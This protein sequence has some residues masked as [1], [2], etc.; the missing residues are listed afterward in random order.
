MK[1]FKYL[2]LLSMIMV[3]GLS[4]VSC[5]DDD[6]DNSSGSKSAGVLDEKTGLRVTSAGGYNYVYSDDGK[7]QYILYSSMC[8]Y[9]FSYS[10]NKITHVDN[11]DYDEAENY[12][13]SYNGSG[14]ISSVSEND[15]WE[16]EDERET[17]S[18]N[19]SFSY[20][21]SGHLTKVSGTY[22]ETESGYDKEDGTY[23]T[24][25]AS[26][27]VTWT[28]TWRNNLL[29]KIVMLDE[30]REDDGPFRYEETFSFSYNNESMANY[31][32]K[33]L[34]YSAFVDEPFSGF[35]MRLCYVGL[36]GNGPA[37]LPSKMEYDAK[38]EYYSD[39][40]KQNN[41]YS[42]SQTYSYDFNSEGAISYVYMGRLKDTYSYDHVETSGGGGSSPFTRAKLDTNVTSSDRHK[43]LGMIRIHKQRITTK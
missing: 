12:S 18:S 29:Q 15:T 27:T 37:Y 17:Y 20:D 24:D 31:A 5:S 16:D 10:P 9:E 22:K 1:T 41:D 40:E 6:D 23:H 36:L 19:V 38:E 42:G 21:D 34:Q 3:G 14:Y 30:G 28:F 4:F 13:I 33:Y 43:H 7:L 8:R 32:N 2:F 35:M 26:G 25:T 39:G 11:G